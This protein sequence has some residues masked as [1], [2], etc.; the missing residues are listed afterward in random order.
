MRGFSNRHLRRDEVDQEVGTRRDFARC[1]ASS[2]WH[3][4]DRH[5]TLGRGRDRTMAT[6][7]A[8]GSNKVGKIRQVMGAVVDVQFDGH[9]PEILNALETRNQGSRLVLEV[10]QH[11]GENTVR[12]IAMDSLRRPDARPGGH[13][14]RPADLGAGRRR[15]ARPHHERDRRAGRRGRPRQ[16]RGDAAPSTS[17][18]RPSPS[19]RRKPRSWS[20]ASRSSTCWRPTP[21][22]AR[23]ACSAAPASARPC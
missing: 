3:P 18:R 22:A 12:T 4:I 8:A 1:A 15:D 17:R 10:A 19:S 2:S 9:L 16:D 6:A 21:R 14:H 23:S 11:L 20:P 13:R 5:D 7:A